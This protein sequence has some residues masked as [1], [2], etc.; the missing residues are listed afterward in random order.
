MEAALCGQLSN[1]GR[2]CLSLACRWPLQGSS[3]CINMHSGL[4]VLTKDSK[5]VFLS[6]CLWYEWW[7]EVRKMAKMTEKRAREQGIS[8]SLC[9]EPSWREG[10][11]WQ[12]KGADLGNS[13]AWRH[14]WPPCTVWACEGLFQEHQRTVCTAETV[15]T[16]RRAVSAQPRES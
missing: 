2:M 16:A 8:H 10:W 5:C 11:R 13:E 14:K 4:N 12:A 7:Q 3:V 9:H 1:W 15:T 6:A